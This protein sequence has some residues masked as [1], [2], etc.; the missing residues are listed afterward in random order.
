MLS[1]FRMGIVTEYNK[2]FIAQRADPYIIKGKDGYYYFT[3]SVPEY[4]R[5]VLRR[6]KELRELADAEEKTIW[7]CHE[8]GDMSKHIWAP[9]MHYLFGRWYMYFAA[10]R[11]DDIW[12]LRPYVLECCGQDP[13][14]DPWIEKG[15]LL[16]SDDDIY[17]FKAFS[18]DTTIFE[19]KG[20]YYCVWAEKVSVGI[21]ISNL[22]IA[23]MEDPLKMKTA[24]VLL[25]TPDYDWERVNI[26]V[27]EGPSVIKKNGM[28]FLTYSASATGPEYCMGMLSIPEDAEILDPKAWKK[29]RYPVLSSEEKYGFYG[30]GHNSFTV[31]EDGS[32]VCVL[33][34]RTYPEI[35]GDPLYD[36]NRHCYLMKMEWKENGKP[37]FD[38]KNVF[39]GKISEGADR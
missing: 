30:P 25:T 23:E 29:E 8:N 39:G 21:Q 20:K 1:N 5:I 13:Y 31:L 15:R 24:Q 17:S 28:I 3:A 37:V 7:C 2:P 6:A 19:N 26:W 14:T 18:L 38:Y 33:H 11:K 9:E 12:R 10:S 4:D 27:N 34:A 35:I 32:E 22:Y 16:R 36:P